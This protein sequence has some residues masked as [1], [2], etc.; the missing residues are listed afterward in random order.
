[1]KNLIMLF[2][3]LLSTSNI[4]AEDV[5]V[6][7]LYFE[8]SKNKKLSEPFAINVEASGPM[9]LK[10]SIFEA[11]QDVSGKLNFIE[12]PDNKIIKLDQSE[13]I[14]R[15]KGIKKVTGKVIFPA[16]I[17]VTKI[18]AVMVEE[19]KN[20]AQSGIGI[21]VRYAVVMKITSSNKRIFERGTIEKGVF[22]VLKDKYVIEVPFINETVKDFKVIS[23]LQV[24]D[25]N[26]KLIKNTPLKS[27]SSWQKKVDESIIFPGAKVNLV[28]DLS[29]ISK[30]GKY[31]ATV[32]AKINGKRTLSK[33]INFE[34]TAEDVKKLKREE[35][36]LAPKIL[37]KSVDMKI[38]HGK[39][40]KFRMLVENTTAKKNTDGFS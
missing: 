12:S 11:N 7:P 17:N 22:K 31:K 38:K 3:L 6:T 4:F 26:N 28:G 34:L 33:K 10:V 23:R 2:I 5:S 36:S 16:R 39:V 9:K 19:D 14:Y 27:L 29:S 40:E 35:V 1:M 8:F 32:F 30:A 15:R 13:Y 21:M 37:P 24:R 25:E 18:Y 20:D